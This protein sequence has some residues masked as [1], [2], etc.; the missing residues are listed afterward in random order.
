MILN[1]LNRVH[2]YLL[3]I[4]GFDFFPFLPDPEFRCLCNKERTSLRFE[5]KK[6]IFV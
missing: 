1:S 5:I 4:G 2:R 3:S 6:C